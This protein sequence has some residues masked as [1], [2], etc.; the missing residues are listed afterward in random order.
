MDMILSSVKIL[1]LLRL[2][3]AFIRTIHTSSASC[4]PKYLKVRYVFTQPILQGRRA[5]STCHNSGGGMVVE[6]LNGPIRAKGVYSCTTQSIYKGIYSFQSSLMQKNW[7]K[8]CLWRNKSHNNQQPHGTELLAW[9]KSPETSFGANFWLFLIWKWPY[10][11]HF[12]VAH[13]K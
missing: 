2:Q 6:M 12:Y 9:K 7:G 13:A 1:H 4:I 11:V 5:V 10:F 3:T 8:N